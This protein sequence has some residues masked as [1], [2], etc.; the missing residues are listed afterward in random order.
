MKGG[1]I[2]NNGPDDL[3]G[4]YL[5]GFGQ[6]TISLNGAVT[7]TDTVCTDGWV[8]GSVPYYGSL[9]I[10]K[11]FSSAVAIPVSLLSYEYGDPWKGAQILKA[12]E[13]ASITGALAAI[14]TPVKCYSMTYGAHSLLYSDSLHYGIDSSGFVIDLDEQ[15]GN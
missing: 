7:I 1:E 3:P 13:D 12:Q 6:N 10:G 9:L 8:D 11:N 14:F 15:N 5:Y 2:S 4:V